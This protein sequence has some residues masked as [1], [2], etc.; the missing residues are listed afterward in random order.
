[1]HGCGVM[2]N[3]LNM[4]RG[5]VA[6]EVASLNRTSDLCTCTLPSGILPPGAPPLVPPPGFVAGM[7]PPPGVV[8]LSAPAQVTALPVA[9]TVSCAAHVY[10]HI[11]AR[12]HM[13]VCVCV[14][15]CV[16]VRVCVCACMCAYVRA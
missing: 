6:A 15:V 11:Y 5:T 9:T 3:A 16:C 1:M 14:C 12:M 13:F 2:R 8:P 4:I 10:V 7:V